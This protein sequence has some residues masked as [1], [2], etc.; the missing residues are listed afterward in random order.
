MPLTRVI[1]KGRTVAL[2]PEAFAELRAGHARVAVDVGTGDGRFAY[3]LA[4]SDPQLLVVGLDALAAPMGERAATA[5]R[6][7]PKGGRPNLVF[8]HAAIEAPPADLAGVADDLYVLLPWG[9]LLEGVVLARDDVLAGIAAV[10]RPGACVRVTLN[11][12]IWIDST[13]TR[14]EPLPVP[15]PEYVAE[16]IAPGFARHGVILEGGRYSTAEEAKS[17]PTTWARKLGHAREHP[18]FVQFAGVA[19]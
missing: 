10:C 6:K 7:P 5:A 18:V 13:P 16:V 12:E 9:A 1:G 8:V 17:L 19:G 3:H 2:E 15:T 11:G 14:Y 4:S